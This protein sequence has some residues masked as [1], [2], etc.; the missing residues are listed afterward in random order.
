MK[1][2]HGMVGFCSASDHR[3]KSTREFRKP[4]TQNLREVHRSP[5][6]PSSATP[7]PACTRPLEP[8]PRPRSSTAT[9][10]PVPLGAPALFTAVPEDIFNTNRGLWCIIEEIKAVFEVVYEARES[11]QIA[12]AAPEHQEV[13]LL[14][15]PYLGK[16]HLVCVKTDIQAQASRTLRPKNDCRAFRR[17]GSSSLACYYC[18]HCCHAP[19]CAVLQARPLDL[20]R[21]YE[22]FGELYFCSLH[23]CSLNYLSMCGC[24]QLGMGCYRV[25]L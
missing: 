24:L 2:Q 12:Q 16:R 22:R 10:A 9:L 18:H 13:V 1:S 23:R 14:E 5:K 4:R 19:Q 17:S 7:G 11:M 20:G 3:S 25:C 21:N 8:R 15:V 6:R